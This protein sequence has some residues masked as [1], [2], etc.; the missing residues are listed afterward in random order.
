[1]ADRPLAVV[2]PGQGAQTPGMGQDLARRFPSSR[3]AFEEVDEAL[4]YSLSSLI[5]DGPAERLTLTEYAQP[6]IL[7]VSVAAW[8]ALG[9]LVELRPVVA[10]GHS[11]GEYTALVAAG[12]LELADAVR[13]VRARGRSMQ[14]AVPVGEGAMAAV[15]GLEAARIDA[16]LASL[17]DGPVGVAGYNSPE[18]T[19]ISGTAPAVAAASPALLA[20]GA[21]R[22]RP[23]EVSA[24]FHS[25]LMAPV[26][27]DLRSVLEPLPLAPFAFPVVAN[28]DA[29]AN[30]DPGRVVSLLLEQLTAPVR[31]VQSVRAMRALGA[32][33][34]VELGPGRTLTALV[35]K[36]DRSLETCAVP[37]ADGVEAAAALLGD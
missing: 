2:F 18:Q 14:E 8:R 31:W 20:A 10:A 17:C 27:A 7:A 32:T 15:I 25:V 36:T 33:R 9:E 4:G 23:L 22:V 34:F 19:T 28:A 30:R 11:L 24:P 3:R 13:A 1:M 16:V 6:A 12:V 21:R 26:E 5:A 35:K 37:D 29:R